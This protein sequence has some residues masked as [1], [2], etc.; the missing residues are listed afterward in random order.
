MVALS[1]MDDYITRASNGYIVHRHFSVQR[2]A[3]TSIGVYLNQLS[4]WQLSPLIYQVETMPTG[5]T[6]FK[7]TNATL[8]SSVATTTFFCVKLITLGTFNIGT[9]TYTDGNTMPT[10]TEG[11]VSRRTYSGILQ[12]IT[13]AFDG[14]DASWTI[15]Y[16]D[17]DN[18]IAPVSPAMAKVISA[19][20]G[21]AGFA[22]LNT[23]D[24]G[25]TD[26]SGAART[27][28]TGAGVITF[29]GVVPL[30][31]FAPMLQNTATAMQFNNLTDTPCP[32][33]LSAGDQIYLLTPNTLGKRFAGTL[34]FIGDQA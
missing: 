5:V 1:S 12:V 13:T 15:T 29:Y 9:N 30:G 31:T 2:D 34:T 11:G 24:Y 10:V 20:V 23:G 18:N 33:I 21:T 25:C 17:Q 28:G 7:L 22:T 16:R 27:A 32:P 14:I 19:G 3:N 26:I 4:T 8:Y 6:A